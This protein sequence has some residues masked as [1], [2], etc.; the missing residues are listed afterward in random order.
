MMRREWSRI[1]AM[2]SERKS[3]A[4]LNIPCIPIMPSNLSLDKEVPGG[5]PKPRLLAGGEIAFTH[6]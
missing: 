6:L 4:A 3:K 1:R 5:N 2:I